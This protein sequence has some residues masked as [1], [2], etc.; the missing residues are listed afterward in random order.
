M[1]KKYVRPE[2][3]LFVINLHE[4]IALSGNHNIAPGVQYVLSANGLTGYITANPLAK[5]DP[6]SYWTADLSATIAF[7][8]YIAQYPE[9]HDNCYI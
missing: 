1:K 4:N 7:A 5:F 2:S 3:K 8:G 9:L 6:H